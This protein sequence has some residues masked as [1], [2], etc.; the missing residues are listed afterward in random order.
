[1]ADLRRTIIILMAVACVIDFLGIVFCHTRY[2]LVSSWYA[3][4]FGYSVIFPVLLSLT[5]FLLIEQLL[6]T[7][8]TSSPL[9]RLRIIFAFGAGIALILFGISAAIVANDW[10]RS[11]YHDAYQSAVIAAVIGFIGAGV[12]IA[13]AIFRN[14][15]S[16]I[17]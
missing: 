12:Y 8:G 5:G 17:V 13:E 16:G 11:Y 6:I 15:K 2:P 7:D 10:H 1:M 4:R 9:N 3:Y 14:R